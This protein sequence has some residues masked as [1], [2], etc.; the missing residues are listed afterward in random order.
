MKKTFLIILLLIIPIL[1]NSQYQN[2]TEEELTLLR[3][4][5]LN[6]AQI[7]MM[8]EIILR[9]LSSVGSTIV[10]VA[11]STLSA[12]MMIPASLVAGLGPG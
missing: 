12:S 3:N 8:E 11:A 5:A 2:Y 6:E 9:N 1:G 4:R 7:L 10:R